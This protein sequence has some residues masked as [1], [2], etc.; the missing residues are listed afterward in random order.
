QARYR[1]FAGGVQVACDGSNIHPVALKL[2]QL[3]QADGSYLI[4]TPQTILASG[5]TAGLG[6]SSYSIPSTYDE[7]QGLFNMAYVISKKHTV[8]GRLYHARTN[9]HRAYSSD[10]LRSPETPPIPGFPVT[11]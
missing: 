3:K 2:L 11:T 9:T 10:F 8:T 4:P 6:F 1:T 5:V 7:D